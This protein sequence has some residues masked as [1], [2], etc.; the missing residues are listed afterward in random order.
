MKN[1]R[2][3]ITLTIFALLV[4]IAIPCV[5]AAASTPVKTVD[6]MFL[7]DTHSHLQEFATVENGQSNMLGGFARIKTL[8]N[9]Q[10]EKN[11][12][13]LLLD[14]GD[15]SMGT[16]IQ[17]IF[18]EEASEIR[19]LGELG[20]DATTL[21]NHEFDYR[22]RGLANMMNNAVASGD[23]LPAIVVCNVDWEGMEAAGLTQDQQLLQAAFE[24]YGVKKYIVVEKDGVQI[25]ITGVFGEDSLEC[26]PG[27]PLAFKNPVDAVKETVSEIRQKEAVDMIVCVSHSGTWEDEAK[28]EDELLAKSVPELDLIISGHTHTKLEEPIA[29]GDTYIVSAAE[30]GK[31]LGNLSMTQKSD[32]RWEPASY[33]LITVDSAITPDEAAQEKVDALMSV[34]DSRYLEQFGYTRA[35]VLCTNEVDFASSADTASLHTENNLGS[36]MADAYTYAV[37]KLSRTD[38]H[39]VDVAVVPSGTIRDSYA[40][41]NVTVENVFNSFSLG[42]GEDGIPGYPLISVYLTGKELRTAAEIDASISDIMTYARLYTDGLCWS[43]NP[44]RMILNKTTDVYLCNSEEE[45]VELEDDKLYRVVTDFYTSQMLGSVTDL[46]YGLLSIVPKNADGTPITDYT[47]AVIMTGE[48]ELKAWA[49]IA[50]YMDSFEDTD[51]DGIGNVPAKYA[52]PEGRKVVED[53]RNL[54]DLLKNPNKFFFIIV[55]AA[56]V[57]LAV[58]VL[59]LRLAWRLLCRFSLEKFKKLFQATD[60]TMGEP[61]KQIVIFTIPMIIGNIAQ[62]LY[63]T[64]DSIVVGKYVGDNALAAVGSAG[65]IMNLLLVLFMGISMGASIMVAQYFGAKQREELSHT[66]GN[67]ISLTAIAVVII[68]IVSVIVVRPLLILLDTPDS[69]L[70][71]C[72]SYLMIMFLG[73]VGT[74]YYNILSGVLRGLGD[75]FSALIYL[76]VAT[77]INI[78]LDVYFVAELDMG[79]SGV[80]LATVIAQAVSALLCFMRLAKLSAIFDLKLKYMRINGKYS[81]NMIK[82]G[83]PSGLTQAIFSTAMIIVQSLTN[84]FGEVFIAANVI[85]MRVD[86]FAMLPNFSFGTA[87]TTYA[88]QNV[89]AKKFERV[90]KG[91]KQGTLL[92]VLTSAVLTGMILLFGRQLMGIFTETAELVELS[93]RMMGIIAVGYI[94]MAV[95]QSLSGVM[96]GAGDTM[97]PMWIS[98]FTTVIVRVPVAYGISYLTRTPELPSGR[99]ECIFISLLSSWVLGALITVFFYLRGRWKKKVTNDVNLG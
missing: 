68:M 19:M 48:Q 23:A 45:R 27:C 79:V 16:L 54:F 12:E 21:G 96:R 26:T 86:G 55:C 70:D 36:I 75:A 83:L 8:I 51:G 53:S 56:L 39:P 25:A 22:A 35:Q 44:H 29:H 40:R 3:F 74:A 95:T 76:L 24:K 92:A 43:Y 85:V 9:E 18:E 71:W 37:E 72:T 73:S 31:Y 64:V 38:E 30:Y 66:I 47:D 6:V 60:M 41:G 69:I 62:Q 14:A 52:G 82:L 17:V 61:W 94:A 81:G 63:N 59:L 32:G 97:T 15:F 91:A 90:T 67:C 2:L 93:R 57:L 65:P 46:S 5:D 7:H 13:T 33:E 10:K 84:S 20:F 88:G 28:S 11:P 42:I 89:G 49:A 4:T 99:Q 87:M 50:A 80:A 77:V 58:L 78:V 34:V 1:K 98:L